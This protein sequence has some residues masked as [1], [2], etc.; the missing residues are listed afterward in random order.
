VPEG[1][2]SADAAAPGAAVALL[3]PV[4]PAAG[5]TADAP[6]AAPA[7]DATAQKQ[8]AA[9]HYRTALGF[10]QQRD[11]AKAVAALSDAILADPTLAVAYSARG[12]AQ[13]G[14]GKYRDAAEDYGAAVRLDPRLGTPVYGLAECHRVLGDGKRA[15]EMYERYARS[16]A[17]DVRE[18]LRSIAA[19][20]AQE[21]R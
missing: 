11:W 9:Q 21:L 20:R 6:A 19:R 5:G 13:F 17:A 15:A 4:A 3:A 2:A 14:L 18:D 10:L 7:P 1:A 12:S 16:T 8:V